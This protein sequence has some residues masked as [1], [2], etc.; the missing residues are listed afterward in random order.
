MLAPTEFDVIAGVSSTWPVGPGAL[1]VAARFEH[2]RPVDRP[3]FT[4]TYADVRGRYLYSLAQVFP[5]LREALKD[6]DV[7]GWATLGCF[8]LNPSYAARPDNSGLAFLR[9][10][11]HAEVSL[12][13]DLISFGL[14]GTFF[15]D[16]TTTWVV[17]T[18]MDL[19]TEVILHV[20]SLEVHLAYERDMPLDRR[21]L[22]QHFVYVLCAVAFDVSGLARGASTDRNAVISP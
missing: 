12:L 8:A 16:R 7:S 4:Q 15:T 20:D 6:G 3:G 9:L 13:R 22:V 10:A 11:A 14:D 19:T 21:G 18:E 2:D 17:P 1:E 5:K